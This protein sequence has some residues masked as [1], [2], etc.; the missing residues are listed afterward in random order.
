MSRDKAAA[1]ARAKELREQE[2]RQERRRE[3]MLRF[4]I[5]A[6]VLAAVVIAGI[7]I[8]ASRSDDG[9]GDIVAVD[10]TADVSASRDENGTGITLGDEAAPV[11][12][13][14]WIDFSCP[15]C[16]DFEEENGETLDE[17]AASGDAK[18]VYHPASFIDDESAVAANAFACSVDEGQASSFLR[19]AFA[20]QGSFSQDDLVAMGEAVGI[21]GSSF[22]SCV[23]DDSFGGWVAD[24]QDG[25][26]DA[27]VEGTPTIF[28]NGEL[29]EDLAS[30]DPDKLREAIDEAA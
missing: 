23:R 26:G 10:S 29:R 14:I 30:A 1:R 25:M 17:I 13:D 16:R 28:V 20:N 19:T 3:R 11:T 7:A 12:V 8:Q 15:H 21:T 27:G 6:A 22:A 4:G 9:G 18:I 24:V 5:G 2:A